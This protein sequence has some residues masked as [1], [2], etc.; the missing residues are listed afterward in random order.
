MLGA[1]SCEAVIPAGPLSLLHLPLDA[2]G[3]QQQDFEA[4]ACGWESL[5]WEQAAWNP[6]SLCKQRCFPFSEL[7][8]LPRAFLRAISRVRVAGFGTRDSTLSLH[9]RQ[10]KTGMKS[11]R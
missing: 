11:N 6:P 9:H 8:A 4:L 5:E 3:N 7:P 2:P 10:G 1:S